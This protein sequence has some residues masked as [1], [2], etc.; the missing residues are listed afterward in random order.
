MPDLSQAPF[1]FPVYSGRVCRPEIPERRIRQDV[2]PTPHCISGSETIGRRGKAG[3]YSVGLFHAPYHRR[4]GAGRKLCNKKAAHKHC[5]HFFLIISDRI[6]MERLMFKQ[7]RYKINI[8]PSEK[9]NRRP[10]P[11][12]PPYSAGHGCARYESLSQPETCMYGTIAAP[13]SAQQEFL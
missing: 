4:C 10:F 13:G 8:F 5:N 6:S 3:R 12:A 9:P 1:F 11:P 7:L 2:H